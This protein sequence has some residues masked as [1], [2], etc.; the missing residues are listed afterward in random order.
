MGE[1]GSDLGQRADP[2]KDVALFTAVLLAV[3]G[4]G[5]SSTRISAGRAKTNVASLRA[6]PSGAHKAPPGLIARADGIC[7]RVN[8]QLAPTPPGIEPKHMVRLA[9]R[10]A[11]IELRGVAELAKLRPQPSLARDWRQLIVY[12]RTLASELLA[13]GGSAKTINLLKMQTLANA[14]RLI[15]RDLSSLAARD[16]FKDCQRVSSTPASPASFA[17][18]QSRSTVSP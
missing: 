17:H 15:H 12:R 5:D 11:A 16:G 2:I 3:G 14:K 7:R 6:S 8:E 13:F 1:R 10:N 18:G 9:R 4:C